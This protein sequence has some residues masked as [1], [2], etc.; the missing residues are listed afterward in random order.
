MSLDTL[1]KRLKHARE[2]KGIKQNHAAKK[3]GV[4]PST[5][6]GYEKDF[7]D[8][9]SDTLAKLAE[10]YDANLDYLLTGVEKTKSDLDEATTNMI[11]EFNKLSKEDQ[12]YVMELI[13]RIQKNE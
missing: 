13:R 4:A 7:R 12:H 3:I 9:D 10:M 8:P 2:Q 6:A 11:R 5:L 1:G